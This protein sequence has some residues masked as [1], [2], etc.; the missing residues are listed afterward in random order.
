MRRQMLAAVVGMTLAGAP[1]WASGGGPRPDS[2]QTDTAGRE[3]R[4]GTE[5][6]QTETVIGCVTAGAD[7]RTYTMADPSDPT[8]IWTLVAD[9]GVDL[10]DH[11][12][13]KI[14][15]TG[16]LDQVREDADDPPASTADEHPK[17]H[18]S[19]IR[20]ISRTCE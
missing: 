15:A 10:S 17:F 3:S 19:T 18:V 11:A 14:E 6:A 4:Q 16:R 20:V 13:Q 9:A 1:A 2:P 7:G 12:G 8:R 5:T